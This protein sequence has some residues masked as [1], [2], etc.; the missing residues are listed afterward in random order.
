MSA[1]GQKQTY[2]PQKGMTLYPERGQKQPNSF[3]AYRC[4]RLTGHHG[5]NGLTHVKVLAT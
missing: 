5:R 1:L 2:A 3:E 4:F